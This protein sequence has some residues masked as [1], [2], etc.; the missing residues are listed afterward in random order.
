M[1]AFGA[2]V[3]VGLSR[4][5]EQQEHRDAAVA[6]DRRAERARWAISS[7]A[8][9]YV[10]AAAQV[11]AAVG[12]DNQVTAAKFAKLVA[13][14]RQR[15]LAGAS[16]VVLVMPAADAQVAQL[17]SR[18]RSRGA[19]KLVLQ[20]VPGVSEHAFG[21]LNEPLDGRPAVP[22]RDL[23]QSSQ[24]RA[25]LQAATSSRSAAVSDPYVLLK[26][27][28]LPTDRQQLSFAI[29]APIPGAVGQGLV[30]WVLLGLRGQDFA[31]AV[32]R[33]SAQ[34]LANITMSAGSTAEPV[35]A[36]RT[37]TTWAGGPARDVAVDLGQQRWVLHVRSTQL[38]DRG[39]AEHLGVIVACAG[40]LITLLLALL[41][42]ILLSSRRRALTT[43]EAAMDELRRAEA[44]SRRDAGLLSAVMDSIGDGV[45]V[46]DSR[47][48][49]LLHNSAAKAILGVQE[50]A[51]G[52]EPWQEHYG[53]FRPDGVAPFPTEEMPLVRGL[54]GASTDL[55][56]MVIRNAT[57]PEGVMISVTG[58]PLDLTSFGMEGRGAVAVFHDV[59][60]RRR[61]DATLR[62][63]HD[64]YE[65]LLGILSDLG[66]GVLVRTGYHITY[67]NDAY[68]QLTG[69]SLQELL[70]LPDTAVLAADEQSLAE[71][72]A[73]SQQLSLGTKAEVHLTRIRHK[74]GHIVPVEVAA[75]RLD[76]ESLNTSE[77]VFVVRDLTERRRSEAELAARASALQEATSNCTRPARQLR[78]HPGPSRSS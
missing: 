24:I 44:G 28:D 58:R 23:S 18:W 30:G 49:F 22:G 51:S 65:R 26:D 59:T 20:P 32:L 14:L 21:V 78:P 47:G 70:A 66:E 50:D 72:T 71:F 19:S 3:T 9:R 1:L 60:A 37:G 76:D 34:G 69:Y 25:A 43:A 73:I 33:T 27:R 54:A 15:R 67:A 68:T 36:V 5:A 4:A 48:A 29:V 74:D 75:M 12:A 45:G 39:R 42:R 13:P 63:Q 10:T 61:L 38:A 52:P 40:G 2:V 64:R 62:V 8:D 6:V 53:M 55:I 57:R 11:A 77:R 56:D 46:V 31:D 41:T 16:G 17:Q 35:A 7:E